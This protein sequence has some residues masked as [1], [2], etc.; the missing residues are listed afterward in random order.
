MSSAPASALMSMLPVAAPT[1]QAT[2]TAV[3]VETQD[4]MQTG[5]FSRMLEAEASLAQAVAT[6]PVSLPTEEN[7]AAE[8]LL[9]VKADPIADTAN[10]VAV[11]L[12]QAAHAGLAPLPAAPMEETVEL[13]EQIPSDVELEL[14]AG[15]DAASESIETTQT[16]KPVAAPRA[17]DVKVV[18]EQPAKVQTAKDQ[19]TGDQP[20]KAAQPGATLVTGKESLPETKAPSDFRAIKVDE[21]AKPIKSETLKA[22]VAPK[23]LPTVEVTK[24]STAEATLADID[25]V[26]APDEAQPLLQPHT[27]DSKSST[28]KPAVSEIRSTDQLPVTFTVPEATR[29]AKSE[30]MKAEPQTEVIYSTD[31]EELESV[32]SAEAVAS[33]FLLGAAGVLNAMAPRQLQTNDV[34]AE[35]SDESTE[36]TDLFQDPDSSAELETALSRSPKA[37]LAETGAPDS[38]TFDFEAIDTVDTRTPV[39][40]EMPR[41]NVAAFAEELGEVRVIATQMSRKSVQPERSED[42]EQKEAE[43]LPVRTELRAMPVDKKGGEKVAEPAL[44]KKSVEFAQ[45]FSRGSGEK[46]ARQSSPEGFSFDA[47]Q[48]EI[49]ASAVTAPS[50][51]G[52][53]PETIASRNS[54]PTN[55]PTPST[56]AERLSGQILEAIPNPLRVTTFEI[57]PEGH[58]A[59]RV[60][61]S[62]RGEGES[63]VW[64]V[65]IQTSD[66][67]ARSLLSEHLNE[68]RERLP[69]ENV[70]VELRGANDVRTEVSQRENGGSRERNGE[71]RQSRGEEQRQ[72]RQ[73]KSGN[74]L[75]WLKA[76]E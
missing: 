66:P 20:L 55:N 36:H 8:A 59:I 12:A 18:E 39:A 74:F 21:Q 56:R 28:Q 14:E 38:E 3:P 34:A 29:F 71:Q 64:R 45:S 41:E 13:T 1:V 40:R 62:A 31:S 16:T 61:I 15:V 72:P 19:L 4:A 67:A 70:Q 24:L 44:S 60:R 73:Q 7:V 57:K 32:E 43:I 75:E 50:F 26:E 25:C 65:Q 30:G 17:T 5:A 53:R 27:A 11:A 23:A 51:D 9:P 69:A 10:D 76:Q 6:M 22:T 52:G 54:T 49:S 35:T 63:A 58:G 2:D 42:V 37:V 48:R 68:L 33:E 46:V 47:G